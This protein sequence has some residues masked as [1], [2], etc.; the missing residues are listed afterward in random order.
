MLHLSDFVAGRKDFI[1]SA[2]KHWRKMK[3]RTHIHLDISNQNVLILSHLGD[4][5]TCSERFTIQSDWS[6]SQL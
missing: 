4:F 2:T 1:I 5:L 3:F 6:I